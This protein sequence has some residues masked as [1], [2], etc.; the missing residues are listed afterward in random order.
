MRLVL[1]ESWLAGGAR[2]PA[3]M[4]PEPLVR[5]TTDPGLQYIIALPCNGKN[6]FFR[7]AC[8]LNYQFRAKME[9]VPA[10]FWLPHKESRQHRCAGFEGHVREARRGTCFNAEEARKYPLGRRHIGVHQNSYGFAV[11]HGCQQTAGKIVLGEQV[12]SM[13]AADVVD[14]FVEIAVIQPADHH[15]H[16]KAHQRVIEAGKLPCPEMS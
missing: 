6:I 9:D 15:R 1:V 11:V 5:I 14:E 10:L 3:A 4:N 8:S 16:G 2:L 7:M 13:H 12:V